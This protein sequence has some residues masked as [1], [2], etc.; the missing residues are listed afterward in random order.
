MHVFLVNS[1]CPTGYLFQH[2]SL[3]QIITNPKPI[4]I[5]GDF[6]I[7]FNLPSDLAALKFLDLLETFGLKQHVNLATHRCGHTL[8]LMIT[9]SDDDL[10]SNFNV[11][12]SVMESLSKQRFCQ[13]GR[14]PEVSCVVIGG[15]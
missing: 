12:D 8:D 5:F 13:H 11:S 10:V 3:D 14:Q 1:I 9:R 4:I 7:Q 15:E 6:N 2:V